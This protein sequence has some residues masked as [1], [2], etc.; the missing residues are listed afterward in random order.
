MRQVQYPVSEKQYIGTAH[1]QKDMQY[2][3]ESE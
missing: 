1:Y 2:Y 3:N